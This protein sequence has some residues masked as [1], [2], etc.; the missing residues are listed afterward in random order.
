MSQLPTR[1]KQVSGT[2]LEGVLELAVPESFW[3]MSPASPSPLLQFAEGGF[4]GFSLIANVQPAPG[5]TL[6]CRPAYQTGRDSPV[7]ILRSPSSEG[8]AWARKLAAAPGSLRLRPASQ[9]GSPSA[10]RSETHF[11]FSIVTL[12]LHPSLHMQM[13]SSSRNYTVIRN[14]LPTCC[15]LSASLINPVIRGLMELVW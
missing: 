14:K 7:R 15:L 11:L 10:V 6:L 13:S 2:V 1:R 8:S 5:V 9:E 4:F 12:C 3:E